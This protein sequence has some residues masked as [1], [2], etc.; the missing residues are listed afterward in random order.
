MKNTLRTI[1]K[2]LVLALIILGAGYAMSFSGVYQFLD[3]TVGLPL[4]E[5]VVVHAS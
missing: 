3:D 4:H 1:F 2:S 5:W